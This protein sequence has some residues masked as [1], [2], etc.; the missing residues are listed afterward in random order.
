MSKEKK[1]DPHEILTEKQIQEYRLAFELFLSHDEAGDAKKA[2]PEKKKNDDD[3]DEEEVEA[4]EEEEEESITLDK[5]GSIMISLFQDP[6]EAELKEMV[7]EV[8]EDGNGEI[9][10][11]EFLSLMVSKNSQLDSMGEMK[12]AFKIFDR[13]GKGYISIEGIK[14]VFHHI[15]QMIT[16]EECKALIIENDTTGSYYTTGEVK[17]EFND[18][19]NLM[20]LSPEEFCLPQANDQILSETRKKITDKMVRRRKWEEER[21]VRDTNP[22]KI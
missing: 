15:G 18:F 7:Q 22:F 10:F 2:K 1:V 8:D 3:D 16:D 4:D 9:D 6:S 12:E 19:V 11:D 17:L 14:E 5:L 21:T 20:K 13:D